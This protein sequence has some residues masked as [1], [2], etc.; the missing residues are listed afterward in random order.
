MFENYGM[1]S[2]G[3]TVVL[4]NTEKRKELKTTKEMWTMV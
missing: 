1:E 4:E 2:R 3:K